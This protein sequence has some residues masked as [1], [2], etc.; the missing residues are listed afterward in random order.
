MS[1]V[2]V[3]GAGVG[4]LAAAVRCAEAGHDVTVLEAAGAAGG[5]ARRLERD[6]FA[7]DTGPSLVTMPWAFRDLLGDRLDLVR[8]EPV[9]RYRFA[10]GSE[11]DL[12]ADLPRAME[13]L[14]AWSPGAG[15][16]WARFLGTCAGMWRASVPFLTG[17]PPWPPRL[18]GPRA[19]PR[20][21]LRVKPWWTLRQLA[22]AHARDPRLRTIV[23][24]FATY[25][26]ADPRRAPAALAVAGYVEHAFG[27]WHPRGGVHAI[28]RALVARAQE[29]GVEIRYGERVVGV[30]RDGRRATAVRVAAEDGDGEQRRREAAP[31]RGELRPADWI[32]WGGD[33]L[34]LARLLRE[35]DPR[36]ERA[37]A[38]LLR[39]AQPRGERSLSGFVL[40]LGL[41]GRTAGLPHHVIAF[42]RSYD[43]EL[44]DVFV[45]RRP[46]REPT[47]YV[48]SPAV[49]DPGEAPPGDESWF[50]LVNAPPGLPE[51]A[52]DGYGDH[53]LEWLA[54]AGL[55][56]SGRVAVR[57]QR[58]PADLERETGAIGGAIYGRAPHG[59]L[60]ALRRPGP[61][62]RGVPNLLRAGGTAHPGGGLPLVALSGALAARIVGPART[63]RA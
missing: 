54:Q 4:G 41:R 35:S 51:R 63:P 13:A 53:V 28:V 31:T 47:L 7:F 59:R 5:K 20:D 42:P 45:V 37:V 18:R 30:A 55:D 32:V 16:D 60:G 3:V 49:T 43:A 9:T 48:S 24:R 11:V 21:A 39:G 38:R 29:L 10:D 25:A 40:M 57:E 22:R 56:V 46:V 61:R 19:D 15:A 34:Q 26:G 12:S 23:E 50:V 8:V 6:G 33:E 62:V 44:D 58:T 52:F 2:V 36:G 27:A 1:R 17:E 14:E